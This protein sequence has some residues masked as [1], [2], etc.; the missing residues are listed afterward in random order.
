MCA[1]LTER[2]VA[3]QFAP[4]ALQVMR[5]LPRTPSGKIQKFALRELVLRA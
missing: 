3:K 5:D 1:F 2:G 4:E